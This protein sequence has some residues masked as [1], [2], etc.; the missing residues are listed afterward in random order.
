MRGDITSSRI[1]H[2]T[3]GWIIDMAEIGITTATMTGIGIP[4]VIEI[5]MEGAV[6]ANLDCGGGWDW[7]RGNRFMRSRV[8]CS[9]GVVGGGVSGGWGGGRNSGQWRVGGGGG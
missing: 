2:I 8:G 5:V 1:G 6:E 3:S 4:I 7:W 9:A